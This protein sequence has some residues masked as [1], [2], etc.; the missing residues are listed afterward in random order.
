MPDTH[1]QLVAK[2]TEE[3]GSAAAQHLVSCLVEAHANRNHVEG[4]LLL[5]DELQH[6]SPKVARAAIE[7]LPDMQQRGRLSDV[8]LWNWLSG[9]GISHWNFSACPRRW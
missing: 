1:Q 3:L 7:S 2:L 9:M 5:L 6:V 4:V 8:L